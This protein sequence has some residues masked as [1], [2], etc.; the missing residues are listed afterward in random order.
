MNKR[1]C[2]YVCIYVLEMKMFIIDVMDHKYNS[3]AAT[4]YR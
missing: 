3:T 1:I 4:I 2:M